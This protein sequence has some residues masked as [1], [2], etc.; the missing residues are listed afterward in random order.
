M[1]SRCTAFARG[2][3]LLFTLVCALPAAAGPGHDG[4]HDHDEAPT[5][6][7]GPSKPRFE[8]HSE[9]FEVVGTLAGNELV[10]TLDDYASNAPI[11]GARI[12]LE[13]GEFKAMGEFRAEQGEYR[14][15]ATPLTVPGTHPI[16]L[17]VSAGDEMDLLAADLVVS[18]PQEAPHA[19]GLGVRALWGAGG[20]AALTALA[21]GLLLVRRR[22]SP[23]TP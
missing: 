8:T 9:L 14:F 2:L 22:H 13:S 15:G 10:L 7:A 6:T 4:G 11:S 21:V 5:V 17:T 3:A 16:T 1:T 23:S 18:A 19:D 12:E 20:V